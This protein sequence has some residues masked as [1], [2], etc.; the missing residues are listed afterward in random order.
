MLNEE[1]LDAV[2]ARHDRLAEA[3]RRAVRA[4]GLEVFCR[5]RCGTRKPTA[6]R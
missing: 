3:A 4:W 6:P 1:G 2:F 5:E